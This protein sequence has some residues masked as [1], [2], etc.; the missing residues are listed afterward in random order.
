MH[1]Y[2]YALTTTTT[3]KI[4]SVWLQIVS[5]TFGMTSSTHYYYTKVMQELFIDSEFPDGQTTFRDITTMLDFWAV[6][7]FFNHF[8]IQNRVKK[9]DLER[10]VKNG[11]EVQALFELCDVNMFVFFCDVTQQD[12]CI[13]YE[14][15]KS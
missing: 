14:V 15:V 9:A 6:R 2:V 1:F 3:K 11:F 13:E 10:N 4:A 5:V 7:I 12:A 8:K